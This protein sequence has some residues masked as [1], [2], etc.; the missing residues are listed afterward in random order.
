MPGPPTAARPTQPLPT[1][2]KIEGM[3]GQQHVKNAQVP[4]QRQRGLRCA[5]PQQARQLHLQPPLQHQAAGGRRRQ[6]AGRKGEEAM[7]LAQ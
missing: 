7:P 3:L 5:V 1:Y 6:P 4:H 2:L